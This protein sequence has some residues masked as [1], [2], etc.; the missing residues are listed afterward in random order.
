MGSGVVLGVGVGGRGAGSVE[1]GVAVGKGDADSVD[2][3]AAVGVRV[4][5]WAAKLP[6]D[7]G[8]SISGV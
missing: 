5:C 7:A 8:S 2:R 4:T 1:K 6:V 3:G